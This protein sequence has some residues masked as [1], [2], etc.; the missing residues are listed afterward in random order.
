[1]P[2]HVLPVQ[3]VIKGQ[4]RPAYELQICDVYMHVEYKGILKIFVHLNLNLPDTIHQNEETK[5]SNCLFVNKQRGL[6]QFSVKEK[7]RIQSCGQCIFYSFSPSS[8]EFWPKL[9]ASFLSTRSIQFPFFYCINLMPPT[10]LLA[11]SP[12]HRL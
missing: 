5:L 8:A 10:L 3:R 6:F 2:N 11:V 7:E 12:R 9:G 4:K 1:M